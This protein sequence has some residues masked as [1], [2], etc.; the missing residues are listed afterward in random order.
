M[1]DPRAMRRCVVIATARANPGSEVWAPNM[2]R[3]GELLPTW[4]ADHTAAKAYA[5]MR[6][7]PH[8][9]RRQAI[10]LH[11]WTKEEKPTNG[12]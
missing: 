5:D 10:P 8:G 4:F 1:R 9:S 11:D 3:S 2:L 12:N 7:K 6:A